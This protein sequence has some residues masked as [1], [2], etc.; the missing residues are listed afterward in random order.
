MKLKTCFGSSPRWTCF[1][2]A[3]RSPMKDM[4]CQTG[5]PGP[6]RIDNMLSCKVCQRSGVGLTLPSLRSN[7]LVENLF[8][9]QF[10]LFLVH[11]PT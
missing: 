5:H 6:D 7:W 4:N 1:S 11:Q 8:W 10:G 3:V 2:V 9:I